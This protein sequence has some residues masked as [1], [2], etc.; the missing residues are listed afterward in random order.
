MPGRGSKTIFTEQIALPS[1]LPV[2]PGTQYC[3]FTLALPGHRSPGG[4]PPLPRFR[5]AP[6]GT[7]PERRMTFAH[8]DG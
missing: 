1:K 6:E 8:S 4:P 2:A 5:P 3:V 7:T